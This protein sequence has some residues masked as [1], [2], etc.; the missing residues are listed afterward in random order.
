MVFAFLGDPESAR[1]RAVS[2]FPGRD[3]GNSDENPAFVETG[4]LFPAVDPDE[5]RAA[6]T[7]PVPVGNIVRDGGR[8]VMVLPD[9]C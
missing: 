9:V 1:M 6:D 8:R 2:F 4:L 3:L 7:V 5:R